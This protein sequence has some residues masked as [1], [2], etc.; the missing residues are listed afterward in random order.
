MRRP[1]EG[2]STQRRGVRRLARCV[3]TS[4]IPRERP[5]MSEE[6]VGEQDRLCPLQMRVA[7]EDHAIV[8][9]R[10]LDQGAHGFEE[11]APYAPRRL[12][13][14]EMEV[15]GDLIVAAAARV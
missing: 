6:V 13:D 5:E 9:L 4:Q 8:R 10:D 7:R 1:A 15:Q 14:K 3:Q 11:S 2:G 12:P